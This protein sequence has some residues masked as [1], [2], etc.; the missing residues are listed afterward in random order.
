MRKLRQGRERP[1]KDAKD[2]LT[3]LNDVF[4]DGLSLKKGLS[5]EIITLTFAP[6]ESKIVNHGLGRIPSYRMILRQTGNAVI[7][8]VD[9]L[10]TDKTIGLLN[11]SA[12]T[13]TLTIK[14]FLE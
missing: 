9:S 12:V 3:R 13:V 14:L 10:W 7:T 4:A 5:G 8:D 11:N 6:N 2:L 1:I